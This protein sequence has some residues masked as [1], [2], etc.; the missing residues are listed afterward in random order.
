MNTHEHDLSPFHH[1]H[2]FGD[3]GEAARGR[4]LLMVTAVTLV[5]MLAE[6]VAGWWTG[7]LAL[8]ADGWHMGTHAA[9]LGG[10]VLAM[11]WSRRAREHEG[12]AFGGWK[13]EV[14]TAY[15]SALLLAAVAVALAVESVRSLVHPGP[16][17]YRDAMSVAVLGLLVNLASVWLL[18][19]AGGDVHGH[20]WAWAWAQQRGNR[21]QRGAGPCP[22]T[23]P[24]TSAST[25]APARPR[26]RQCP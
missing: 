20:A 18:A 8:T 16:I 17:N 1:S 13:I 2:S 7:S 11:R 10:A 4:A 23:S 3:A 15:T 14:L 6:L 21:S 19:R 9:A 12:F 24:S 22:R 5:T 26:V 25:P